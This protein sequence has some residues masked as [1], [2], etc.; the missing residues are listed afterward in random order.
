M[1]HHYIIIT[2]GFIFFLFGHLMHQTCCHIYIIGSFIDKVSIA[3][4][5]CSYED[6]KLLSKIIATFL[7]LMGTSKQRNWYANTLMLLMWSNKSPHFFILYVHILQQTKIML[8]K[9]FVL[10]MV[11]RIYHASARSL[12]LLMYRSWLSAKLSTIF[13]IIFLTCQL[14]LHFKLIKI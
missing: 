8:N 11:Q 2:L 4:I 5:K 6:S 3:V 14:H 9:F 12:Q 1:Q 13:V 10:Y 7:F